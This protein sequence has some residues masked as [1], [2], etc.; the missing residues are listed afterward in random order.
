MIWNQIASD[1]EEMLFCG[2]I[3][4]AC[5]YYVF[6]AKVLKCAIISSYIPNV[7]DLKGETTGED[8]NT[9]NIEKY[10]IYQNA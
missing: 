2:S 9:E 3:Y 7:N 6:Q 1:D 5:K 8:A 4:E 10:E